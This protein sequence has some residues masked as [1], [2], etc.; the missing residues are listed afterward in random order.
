MHRGLATSFNLSQ[1]DVNPPLDDL[2][3]P[4]LPEESVVLRAELP[5]E[6]DYI[7]TSRG[8]SQ[9]QRPAPGRFLN[10]D[11]PSLPIHIDH[12]P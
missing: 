5:P 11:N 10:S 4:S 8:G 1:V 9:H 3:G 2:I 7:C 6:T 12:C